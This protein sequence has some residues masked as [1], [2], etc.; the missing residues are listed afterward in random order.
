MITLRDHFAV[1]ALTGLL[2]GAIAGAERA[3]FKS[4]IDSYADLAYA[5]ADAMLLRSHNAPRQPRESE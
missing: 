3:T 5:L 2:S 4:V 1:A